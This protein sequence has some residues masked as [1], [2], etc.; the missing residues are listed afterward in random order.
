VGARTSGPDS[1]SERVRDEMAQ[2]EVPG[3]AVGILQ[4]GAAETAG[5]GLSSVETGYPVRPDALFQIGSITKVFTATLVMRLEDEGRLSLDA[6]VIEYLPDLRLADADARERITLRHLL[7]HTSGLEGDH[8]NFVGPQYGFGDDAIWREIA[9]FPVLRQMTRPGELWAYCNAGFHL[10]GAIA[11]RVTG[12]TYEATMREMLFEPLGLER[13]FLFAHEAIVYPVAVGHNQ[14]PG[15]TPRVAR[16]YPRPRSCHPAGAIIS[17]VGDLLKFAHF[18]LD[19]GTVDGTQVLSA[20]SVAA[21]QQP[22]TVAGNFAEHYGLGWALHT[23]GGERV[24]GH[25]G[26]TNGFQAQLQLV[27]T[28]DFA[29]AVLT[30]SNRGSAAARRIID[31]VIEERLGLC[32]DER[33]TF[34]LSET[35]LAA[36]AGHYRR[37]R[38][39]I[40]VMAQGQG[41]VAEVTADAPDGSGPLRNPPV[42]LRPIGPREFMIEDGEMA[43]GRVDFPAG[44]S[45]GSALIRFGG[46]LAE[47]ED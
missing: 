6:P 7:T 20:G 11:A 1:L 44:S 21:M 15:G 25:G 24:V 39:E 36:L 4:H 9:D 31:G 38:I 26:T 40:D 28:R 19:G 33:S 32:E 23:L 3:L 37:P 14:L 34:P 12:Q 30:N 45:S 2:W 29:I 13:T 47:R 35:D 5:F 42:H 22:Q 27:P 8:F 16:V 10:A 43:G 18:H 46:R 41:L 17:T